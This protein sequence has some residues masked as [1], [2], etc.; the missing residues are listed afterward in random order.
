MIDCLFYASD[1]LSWDVSLIAN[2]VVVSGLW[3]SQLFNH[4]EATIELHIGPSSINKK[5][6]RY[7]GDHHILP[8]LAPEGG[9]PTLEEN[10]IEK[11]N[12]MQGPFF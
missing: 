8:F 10:S 3:S 6:M 7:P 5:R 9:H 12:R 1:N 2:C 4:N 11:N